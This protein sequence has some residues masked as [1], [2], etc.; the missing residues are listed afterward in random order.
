MNTIEKL[1]YLN[2]DFKIFHIKD[3]ERREFNFHYHDFNKIIIFLSGKINYSIE[4]KNYMLN[5]YDI[6]LVNAGEIHK[7]SFLDG[8]VYER[9]IM[10]VS[11]QFLEQ[12]RGED[13]DL[14]SCFNMAKKEHSNVLRIHNMDKSKL[15]QVC[16]ELEHSF[17]DN[18]FARELYQKI[19]FLEFMIHLN[20]A[21]LSGH[22][23]YLNS[24]AANPKL[25][26]ILEYIN[27]HLAEDI[28]IDTLSEEFY[29]SRFYLMHFFKEETGYTIG[30][31]I[32]EKRL[33]LAKGLVQG[34]CTI[35][36]ACYKSGFKNYSTFS[37]AFKKAFHTMPKNA[38]LLD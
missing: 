28:T 35:T 21:A 2:H 15:Y 16:L 25:L 1:G 18:S 32:T 7:P 20:R 11:T 9:I 3:R 38:P 5:P 6:I 17:E 24:D 37:R 34:G 31:Y 19:L 12:Y 13:Y 22:V 10:Y 33:L 29:L 23:N 14:N 30:N 4:G 36:E 27:E 8:S 26:D